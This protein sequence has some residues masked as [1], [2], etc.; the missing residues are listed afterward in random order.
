[1]K[2]LVG[3]NLAKA[4][5]GMGIAARLVSSEAQGQGQSLKPPE[6]S[7]TTAMDYRLEGMA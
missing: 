5:I 1:M 6:Q 4:E 7:T 3:F 2:Y